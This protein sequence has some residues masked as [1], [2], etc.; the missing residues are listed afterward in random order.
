MKIEA[1][2]E[3]RRRR[4][5]LEHDIAEKAGFGGVEAMHHQLKTWGLTGLLPPEKQEETPKPKA[6]EA[7][8]KQKARGSGPSEE[9][10]EVGGAVN[11]FDEVL[12]E[13]RGTLRIVEHLSLVRKGKSFAGSYTFEGDWTFPRSSCSEERWQGL[14]R[15]YDQDP[16]VERFSISGVTSSHPTEAG[17]YPPRESLKDY[18]DRAARSASDA[19]LSAA[20]QTLQEHFRHREE[21]KQ[22]ALQGGRT[23]RP[24]WAQ[25]GR[26][27][28]RGHI[29]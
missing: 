15:Q 6:V 26:R 4:A 23:S 20:L 2:C 25:P 11:L 7:N 29:G 13:L 9:V 17:P 5:Y 14:C 19:E 8:P 21:A 1:L 18:L 28:R 16:D 22:H 3:L 12:D 27:R 10:P 24:A